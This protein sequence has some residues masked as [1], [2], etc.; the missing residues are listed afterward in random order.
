MP[1]CG[2]ESGRRVP[3]TFEGVHLDHANCHSRQSENT[4]ES[5]QPIACSEGLYDVDKQTHDPWRG[6]EISEW[7][8]AA[9]ARMP[10]HSAWC[11]EL[12]FTTSEIMRRES[13]RAWACRQHVKTRM[14]WQAS[15]S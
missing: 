10:T 14:F 15:R 12:R 3:R 2:L 7:V 9:L 5:G 4:Q 6:C 1:I 13:Q 8:A 11:S